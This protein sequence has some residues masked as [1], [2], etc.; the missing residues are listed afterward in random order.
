MKTIKHLLLAAVAVIAFAGSANAQ[1]K[2]GPRVGINVNSLHFNKDVISSDNRTGFNAGVEAEFTVPVIGVGL[3]ASLMYVRR[4]NQI[5]DDDG[6]TNKHCDYFEIP[7]NVKWKMNIPVIA[8]LVK[9]YIFTGPSFAFLTSK[10]AINEAIKYKSVDTSWNFGLG[11][12]FISHL[13]ISAY[14]GLGLNK[15]IIPIHVPGVNAKA[16][17]GKTHCWTVTAAWLF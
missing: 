9:P 17:D 12:E 10:R 6:V 13:Q 14:Y 1:F 15:S 8:K 11:L 4:N 7:V 16:I 2:F 3:D 5:K